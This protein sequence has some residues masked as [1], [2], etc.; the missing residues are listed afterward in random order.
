MKKK[1][2]LLA[3][4]LITVSTSFAQTSKKQRSAESRS[5]YFTKE[6]VN[7]LTRCDS[8]TAK[9]IYEV[10]LVV[11]KQFDSLKALNLSS[12][13]YK[14]A[15]SKIYKNRDAA[16]KAILTPFQYDEYMMLQAEKKQA[17]KEKKAKEAAEK[18]EDA[19]T[20]SEKN[21]AD[22]KE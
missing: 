9:K 7:Y 14:P 11:T 8:A 6:I 13:D 15:A 19:Q 16:M 17:Y 18:K 20:E 3:F 22:K 5:E 4:T 1:L 2:I 21:A 12:E 10:N